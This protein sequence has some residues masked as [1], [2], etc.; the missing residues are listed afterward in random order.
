M[1]TQLCQRLLL[2]GTLL[3]TA[4][5]CAQTKTDHSLTQPAMTAI[6]QT[7]RNKNTV[8]SLY[9]DALNKRNYALLNQLIAEEFTGVRGLK[10]ANAIRESVVPLINAF[11][12]I[13]YQ[14]EEL[15]S[16]GNKVSIRWKWQGTHKAAYQQFASTG[17]LVTNEG[18]AIYELRDNKIITAHVLIDRLGFLQSLGAIPQDLNI[19]RINSFNTRQ[20]RFIDK[21]VGPAAVRQEFIDR[22]N[23]NRQFIKTLNG[24]VEDAA[25]EG[26]DDKGNFT[27]ITMAVWQNE[28]ALKKAKEAVQSEYK[29]EG[30]NPAQ[31]MERL[32][33][34]MDRGVY[35][36]VQSQP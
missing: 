26:K 8:R 15:I 12:D 35:Q 18:M 17:T 22:V 28:E 9:E 3:F 19:L 21:F 5:L 34:T 32:H 33:I 14:I 23:S 31:W 25:Y 1:E 20:V 27:L 4:T 7:E 29:R 16:E 36:Q 11:P 6:S 2:C 24:F 13:N 30:F 10:G